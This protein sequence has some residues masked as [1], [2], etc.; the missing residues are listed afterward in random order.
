MIHTN[1]NFTHKTAKQ[2]LY[3]QWQYSRTLDRKCLVPVDLMVREFG[4]NPR[5]GGSSRLN[6]LSLTLGYFKLP[7]YFISNAWVLSKTVGNDYCWPCTVTLQITRRSENDSTLDR[8]RAENANNSW[9][10][11]FHTVIRFMVICM[12]FQA[13]MWFPQF[14]LPGPSLLWKISKFHG[15]RKNWPSMAIWSSDLLCGTVYHP[16]NFQADG[17]NP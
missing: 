16:N 17:W 13:I 11:P 3:H 6:L 15:T 5:F 2:Y 14:H 4:I 7:L 12:K 8:P 9:V 10:W 1:V